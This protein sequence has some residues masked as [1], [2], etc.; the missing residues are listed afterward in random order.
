VTDD[1]ERIVKPELTPE[2]LEFDRTLRPKRLADYIGQTRVKEQVAIFIEA[3]KTRGEPLDH[4]LLSGPP[5][6]GKTTL[7]HVIANELDV[8]V[9]ATSGPA[10]ER[11][12]DLAAILTNLEAHDVLFI[13]EIHRLSRQVEEVLYPAMEDFQLD[14]VIGKGPAARSLRLEIPHFTLVGATTRTGLL[15]SP[16]RD[17]FGVV[18]RLDYY[19]S[20]DLLAIVTR[21]AAILGVPMDATAGAE[22]ARRSRGTP[23]LANRLLK[24]VRDYAEVKHDGAV[25]EEIA[26]A[27]LAFFEVDELGLDQ[28]D[29]KILETLVEKF[30]GQP[31]GLGTL[32][33]ALGEEADTL[34]D[35]YEPYLLQL[36]FL[37]R[38]PRGR[39]AT[40]RAYQHLGVKGPGGGGDAATLF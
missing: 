27:A 18:A 6:L 29:K 10:I 30:S 11:A 12:G 24:R 37:K 34:E 2:D 38:T 13:D 7:A 40:E 22:I 28:M 1:A 26:C 19:T 31:V 15:T 8:H 16:L 33:T 23:R 25:T 32:A 4:V 21:S 36:G 39:Q 14:I 20:D 3:A 35:V 5:G 9:K 17:R